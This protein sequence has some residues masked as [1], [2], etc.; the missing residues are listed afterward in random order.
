VSQLDI[1]RPTVRIAPF[2]VQTRPHQPLDACRVLRLVLAALWILD[3]ALQL[4]PFMFSKSFPTMLA[5]TAPGNP[6]IISLPITWSASLIGQHSALLNT[7]FA[8]TQLLLG[9][10]IAFR[11]TARA[12]L[13][14]SIGW[15]LSV[16]WLGEGLGGVLNGTANPVS[17]APGAVILYALLAVLLWPAASPEPAP[18]TAARTV[19][20]HVARLVWLTLWMSLAWFALSPANRAPQGLSK[21]ITTAENNEPGWLAAIE[22]TGATLVAGH[23]TPVSFVLAAV[24]VA[25]AAGIWLPA[26]FARVTVLAAVVVGCLFWVFGEALGGLLTGTATDPNSGPPLVL[27]AAAYWPVRTPREPYQA[28]HARPAPLIANRSGRS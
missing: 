12:A 25:I 28:T 7:L 14:A 9:I 18:F 5:A 24:L 19:H 16:W 2:P 3:G 17:G 21:V 4:Q 13:V 26:S 22:R 27:L 10:G 20:P 1:G 8:A 11:P 6:A 23:G 15:A